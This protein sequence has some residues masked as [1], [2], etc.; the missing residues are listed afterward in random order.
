MENKLTK[1]IE[2]KLKINFKIKK[3]DSILVGFSGGP[4]SVF[5]L[6][7]FHILSKNLGFKLG[8]FH[9]NHCLRGIDSENDAVFCK[10]FSKNIEAPFY[11]EKKD[12]KKIAKELKI[13][14]EDAGRKIRYESLYQIAQSNGFTHI[15]TAHHK[16]DSIEQVLMNLIRG[17]G[18]SGL[19]GI[20]EK[21]EKII[22]PLLNIEKKDILSY[23]DS[24]KI[25]YCTD[26]TNFE[27]DYLRNKIRN[28]LIPYL[29]KNYNP[30][31]KKGI[32]N[33]I[34]IASEEN[35]FFENFTKNIFEKTVKLETNKAEINLKIFAD[36]EK[37]VKRRL[38]REVI[39]ALKGTT[40]KTSLD[41]IDK[42]IQISLNSGTKKFHLK[43][44][45]IAQKYFDTLELK[46]SDHCLRNLDN[47]N[48]LDL[49]FKIEK[50]PEKIIFLDISKTIQFKIYI[51]YKTNENL[52]ELEEI[53]LNASKIKFPLILRSLENGDRFSPQNFKG[54]K[55]IKKILCEKRLSPDQKKKIAVLESEGKIY[56]ISGVAINH[57]NA[58]PLKGEKTLVIKRI[59]R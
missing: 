39:K 46:I 31:I 3:N 25:S 47:K 16:D 55:K 40:F 42:I 53:R 41:H 56:W 2:K 13:S 22:R 58:F 5:L 14:E 12:I 57:F 50:L 32:A 44:Q 18:I 49:N 23:L 38:L 36:L 8:A 26:K 30:S 29:E 51:E 9:L 52:N 37:A 28:I 54:R 1:E 35:I 59:L 34:D 45:V 21:R 6:H 11:Y 7:Q 15:A 27:T 17:T 43:D 20:P 4:D 10:N 24:N 19:S 48:S 33:L